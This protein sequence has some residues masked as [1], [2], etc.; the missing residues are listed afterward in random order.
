MPPGADRFVLLGPDHLAV[1]AVVAV[2]CAAL[3]VSRR[4]LAGRRDA[5]VR[6]AV[7]AALLGNE[8][9]SWVGAAWQGVARVPLQLCDL[10]LA[11][12]V[13]ALWS[14]P[15]GASE[16]AYFW[17]LA[18]SL[19]AVLTPDLARGFPD[20]WWLKFFLTHG[21]IVLSA[22]YLAVTGRVAPTHRSVWRAWLLT[23]GYAC[24]AGLI[25][26]GF[27]TNYGYLARKPSQPSLLDAFGPW[28]WYL[29]AMEAAALALLYL[30]Y[31]PF[32][33]MRRRAP[34]AT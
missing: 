17:G 7:A 19:Q 13:W 23:N 31:L 25:N 9:A 21:G 1:L 32:A 20:Y 33:V 18:G 16:L 29:L 8:L 22:V 14:L 3:L 27:G 10:A 2:A 5:W 28:P 34:R 11:L 12:T 24:A 6:R 26:W 15:A 30:C 4:R